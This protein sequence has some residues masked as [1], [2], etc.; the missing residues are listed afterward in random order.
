MLKTL[1]K[2]H[3]LPRSTHKSSIGVSG[4]KLLRI[5][6]DI[7]NTVSDSY[8]DY[9]K[10]YNKKLGVNIQYHEIED[11]YTLGK[12]YGVDFNKLNL[13]FQNC[14]VDQKFQISF[15]AYQDAESI[16]QK[17]NTYGHLIHY[18]T[19]RPH[20]IKKITRKWLEING[21][22]FENTTLDLIH[23]K[24]FGQDADFKKETVERLGISIMIED[25]RE[26]VNA[27]GIPAILLD[28]PWNQGKTTANVKRVSSW[29]EIDKIVDD[30]VSKI[31][32]LETYPELPV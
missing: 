7:D 5:G 29:E 25:M 24:R 10:V 13:I 9:L 20:T 15:K 8:T 16:I 6:I 14:L 27:I 23:M 11:F 28:R 3:K 21:L 17:W 26:I 1:Q 30:L 2:V 12:R 4:N 18:I 19:G 31:G 32:D 22:M